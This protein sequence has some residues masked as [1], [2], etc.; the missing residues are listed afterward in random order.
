MGKAYKFNP[1]FQTDEEAVSNF[2][3]RQSE[4]R[5]IVD[6][7][8]GR[9]EPPRVSVIAPRGAGKTTLCRRVVAEVRT[10]PAFAARWQPIFLGEES[11]IVTTPGEFFLEC[12][13]HLMEEVGDPELAVAHAEVLKIVSE[14]ELFTRC[15]G[16]LRDYALKRRQRLLVVVENFHILLSEQVGREQDL[17]LSAL[18]DEEIFGV[19]ATSVAQAAEEDEEQR[20]LFE[21]Y[22]LIPLEPLSLDECHQL[23]LALTGQEVPPERIRPIQILT[24][25]S[26]RLIHILSEFMRSPS[27]GDLMGNLNQLIDQNTEYF[28]SQLD[29]LPT[30]ERKVF[31]ALLDAWDPSTAK[32]IAEAARV[33]VNT[34]SAMLGRLADRGSVIKEPG[35]GRT[36]HYYAAERLFNIYYLM[37]RRSHPS[38]R[39]RALVAFM[40]EYYDRDELVATT[41]KIVDEACRIDPAKRGDYHW[42]VDEILNRQ[43]ETVRD[44]IIAQTPSEFLQSM[45]QDI[46]I[47]GNRAW[48][49]EP[50]TTLPLT[51]IGELV[52]NSQDAMRSGDI[53]RAREIVE[54][55]I[56]EHPDESMLYFHM[57]TVHLHERELDE[58]VAVAERGLALSPANPGSLSLYG[59]LLGMADRT[60]EAEA[61]FNR[62]LA[63]DPNFAL[64]ISHLAELREEKDDNEGAIKLYRALAALGELDADSLC[65]LARLLLDNDS[66]VEAEQLLRGALEGKNERLEA[67]QILASWLAENDRA[68]EATEILREFAERTGDWMAWADLAAF[69]YFEEDYAGSRTDF[70]KAISEGADSPAV[71][72]MLVQT[73]HETG[74]PRESVFSVARSLT[75]QH[76]DESW[77][78]VLAGDIYARSEKLD[79]AER[80]YRHAATLEDGDHAWIRLAKLLMKRQ[81]H[82]EAD[83]ALLRAVDAARG[84]AG[85]SLKRDVAECLVNRGNDEQARELLDEAV[86][87]NDECYCG[88]VLRG[89]MAARHSEPEAARDYYQ[90]A[91]AINEDGIGA[92]LGLAAISGESEARGYID[93]AMDADPNN[94]QCLLARAQ[95]GQCIDD[96]CYEDGAEALQRDPGLTEAHLFLA[97]LDAARG[98]TDAALAHL[99]SAL[100]EVPHRRELIPAFVDTA[101]RLVRLGLGSDISRLLETEA[102][103]PV[104]PLAV[105]LRLSRGETPAVAKEVLEVARDIHA[106]LESE[107]M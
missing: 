34:A 92:L 17:L 98:N 41:A 101:L 9:L 95:I 78:W 103:A 25:G 71:Y 20:G 90:S 28:K 43:P 3:V 87:Q 23:W 33:N 37:R 35:R 107:A 7:L 82:A 31:A 81:A 10:D 102:G 70:E 57:A 19:L 72:M 52:R 48:G 91:L 97:P 2:I 80:N 32:Q 4:L 18:A 89:D 106:R 61:A 5:T 30:I 42:A 56:G 73:M 93:R 45:R 60:D 83:A 54:A 67:R 1:G 47:I 13:F 88:R 96:D 46:N 21:G 38:S 75:E 55:A 51:V 49:S 77:A 26:P 12:L 63:I 105:A 64:A 79:E 69:R 8:C 27:L 22:R 6:T 62:A 66:E 16:I 11:Y 68:E 44:R 39:V 76:S 36:V 59:L 99:D 84:E 100:R 58:A 29:T 74:E 94:A 40:T 104:E 85:C 15:L 86:A 24:G 14:D 65:R 53:K 50:E